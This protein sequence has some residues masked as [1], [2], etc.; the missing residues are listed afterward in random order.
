MGKP[1]VATKA[2]AIPYVVRDAGL[3]VEVDDYKAAAEI[4]I[5][6]YEEKELREQVIYRGKER[7]KLFDA[8]RTADE[9]VELF[10]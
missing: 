7:V 5:R 10:R 6:L 9:H 4:V 2:D 3:L 8:Q 1:I